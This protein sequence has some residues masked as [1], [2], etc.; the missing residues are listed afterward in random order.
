MSGSGLACHDTVTAL[1]SESFAADTPVGAPGGTPSA[2][3]TGSLR[4][5]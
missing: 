4:V 1:P 5:P 2:K 3:L